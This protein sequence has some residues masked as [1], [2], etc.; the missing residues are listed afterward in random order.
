VVTLK[1]VDQLPVEGKAVLVRVDYNV[2]LSPERNDTR[3]RA[4]LP[5]LR[6]ILERGGRPIAM[7]HLGRPKGQVVPALSLAP[8]RPILAELLGVTV[9]MAP[10]CVGDETSQRVRELPPGEV[11]L[12]ENL[13]F[14]HEEEANDPWFARQLA[15]LGECYVNDAFGSS[16]RAHASVVGVPRLLPSAAGLLLHREIEVLSALMEDPR[17]PFWAL[18]GGAKVSGKIEVIRNLIAKVDGLFVAGGMAFTFLKA[19]GREIGLSLIEE[20]RLEVARDLL[21]MARGRGIPLLLPSDVVVAAEAT[22]EAPTMVVPT[23]AIPG[24][25]KGLDI[26]PATV[27]ELAAHLR[28]ARTVFWNGPCGVFEVE[29]FS[30]GT[31]AVA[32][33]V[34]DATE[35]GAV[36]VVGGGDSVAAVRQMGFEDC[37]THLSTGGGAALELLEGKTLPGVAVLLEAK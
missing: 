6:S 8:V 35:R 12:L 25:K 31:K 3:S 23:P 36:T 5:T 21:E 4:S 17:R 28:E 20:D 15:G 10:D 33:L 37:V 14:H 9:A 22:E 11:L 24:D 26:G 18:L 32:Q 30:Y 27:D 16:H 2:P 29:A 1:T 34:A 19:M 7:S 13:R